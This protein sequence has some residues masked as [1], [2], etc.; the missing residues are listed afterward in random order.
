[1]LYI[2]QACDFKQV[3]VKVSPIAWY[4]ISYPMFISYPNAIYYLSLKFVFV[5][6]KCFLHVFWVHREKDQFWLLQSLIHTYNRDVQMA[7]KPHSIYYDWNQSSWSTI[8]IEINHHDQSST[9]IFQINHHDQFDSN[10]LSWSIMHKNHSNQS[11][12]SIIN[13]NDSNQS[14]WLIIH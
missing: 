10:Q 8:M 3:F 13:K 1:M 12:W 11:S 6:R 5:W 4:L 2:I 14:S 9:R 7:W